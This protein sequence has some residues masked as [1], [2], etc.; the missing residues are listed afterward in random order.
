MKVTYPE[1]LSLRLLWSGTA[2]AGLP[3]ITNDLHVLFCYRLR[4]LIRGKGSISEFSMDDEQGRRDGSITAHHSHRNE[5]LQKEA[6]P[7]WP[8]LPMA[9][10]AGELVRQWG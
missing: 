1:V 9:S 3:L 8:Y 7:L 10:W 5:Q 6:R 4:L 2:P